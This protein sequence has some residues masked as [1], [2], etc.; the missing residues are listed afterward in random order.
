M[1]ITANLLKTDGPAGSAGTVLATQAV[2]APANWTRL[3]DL[4]NFTPVGGAKLVISSDAE[5]FRFAVMDPVSSKDAASADRVPRTNGV[6]VPWFGTGAEDE[7]TVPY[8]AQI[9]VK[10]A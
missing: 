4:D 7:E 6:L 10:A 2:A 9:W 3:T 8:G 5:A 1:T